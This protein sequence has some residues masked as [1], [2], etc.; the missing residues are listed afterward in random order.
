MEDIILE[1]FVILIIITIFF[2]VRN[3]IRKL[4]KNYENNNL[5]NFLV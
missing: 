3:E 1:F 5:G 2:I 4:I